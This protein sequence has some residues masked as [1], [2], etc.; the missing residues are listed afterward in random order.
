MVKYIIILLVI[1]T[2][3]CS[4]KFYCKRCPEKQ[5]STIT[6]IKDTTI[7]VPVQLPKDSSMIKVLLKCDSLNNV[8]LYRVDSL[9]GLKSKIRIVLKNNYLTTECICD[10]ATIL[11]HV[12]Q[13]TIEKIV[14]KT[15]VQFKKTSFDNF[16]NWWFFISIIVFLLSVFIIIKKV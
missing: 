16:T 4:E 5:D 2:S 9:T 14:F 12:K 13:K 1:I 3:S 8:Y 11:K 6:I 7:L 15:N 10:T